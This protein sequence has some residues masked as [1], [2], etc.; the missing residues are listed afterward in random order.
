MGFCP[1]GCCFSLSD[2][3]HISLLF[4]GTQQKVKGENYSTSLAARAQRAVRMF[5]PKKV[6]A[7]G[8]GVASSLPKNTNRP[9]KQQSERVPLFQFFALLLLTPHMLKISVAWPIKPM[10]AKILH[11]FAS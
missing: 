7:K 3:V 2:L 5:K 9:I 6:Q 1:K 8:R 11:L 4:S 10:L